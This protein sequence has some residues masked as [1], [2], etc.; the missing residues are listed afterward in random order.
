MK[1]EKTFVV[2]DKKTLGLGPAVALDAGAP[3]GRLPGGGSTD[4]ECIYKPFSGAVPDA[5]ID[6]GGEVPSRK[7]LGSSDS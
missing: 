7:A 3:P 4:Q 2:K 5:G 1:D 6:R